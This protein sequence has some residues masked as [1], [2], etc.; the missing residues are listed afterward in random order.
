MHDAAISAGIREAREQDTGVVDHQMAVE[1]QVGARSQRRDDGRADR[2]V[3]HEV[4]VHHVDVQ[5]VSL[6]SHA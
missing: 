3:G 1:E 6:R 5:E 2:E 4:P